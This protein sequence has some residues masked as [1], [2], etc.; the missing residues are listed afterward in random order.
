[1]TEWGEQ[2]RGKEGFKE[3]FRV[4][5][6]A[7]RPPLQDLLKVQ[8][9]KCSQNTDEAVYIAYAKYGYTLK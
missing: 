9:N 7:T 1:M 2:I 3:I 5:R 6:Y 4:R 8:Q